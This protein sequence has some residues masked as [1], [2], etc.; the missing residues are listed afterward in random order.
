MKKIRNI[1][2]IPDSFIVQNKSVS[3]LCSVFFIIKAAL[4]KGE[5]RAYD[6]KK[7]LNAFPKYLKHIDTTHFP[8]ILLRYYTF[9]DACRIKMF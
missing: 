9:F 1:N 2:D 7:T 4:H 5:D 8:I 6:G 3:G